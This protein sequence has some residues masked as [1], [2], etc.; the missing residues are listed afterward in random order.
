MSAY[1]KS[2]AMTRLSNLAGRFTARTAK[3][4]SDSEKSSA[5]LPLRAGDTFRVVGFRRQLQSPAVRVAG[6]VVIERILD[7]AVLLAIFFSCLVGLPADIFPQG[8]ILAAI[9][10]ADG[11]FCGRGALSSVAGAPTPTFSGMLSRT[12]AVE[13]GI[14]GAHRPFGRDPDLDPLVAENARA[15]RPVCGRMGVRGD[16]VRDRRAGARR[17]ASLAVAFPC[18]R[19]PPRPF[20]QHV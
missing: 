1:A 14:D 6:T 5:E 9:W 2:D 8:F 20:P 19:L 12:P 7:V 13:R 10:G 11:V 17:R 16:H 18:R 15:L 3:P 4:A